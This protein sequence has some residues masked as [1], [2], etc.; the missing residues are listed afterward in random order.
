MR[1]VRVC[2]RICVGGEVEV[3]NAVEP[4]VTA[5]EEEK[6][7]TREKKR[8]ATVSLEP[9]TDARIPNRVVWPYPSPLT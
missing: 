6:Q 2:I 1:Q 7:V 5:H 8:K 4:S 9:S 3:A